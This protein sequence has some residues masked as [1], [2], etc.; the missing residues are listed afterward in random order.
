[1]AGGRPTL[2]EERYVQELLDYFNREP[3]TFQIVEN[4]KGEMCRVA[5]PAS[6]PTL[7]GFACKIGVHRGTL[8]NWANEHEEFFS[9]LKACKEY[10]E[11]ILIE[12]GLMGGYDKT[13]AIFTAK[14][15]INWRDKTEQDVNLGGQPGNPIQATWNILPVRANANSADSRETT[16][17]SGNAQAD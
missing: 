2:Y 7:A 8:Q 13:F 9:A 14:N 11:H 5:I 16:A 10:Q 3:C 17:D 6:L 1:M 4:S 15:L 12:N